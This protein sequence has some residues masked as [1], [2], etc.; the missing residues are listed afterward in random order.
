MT[1]SIINRRFDRGLFIFF[2]IS[3]TGCVIVDSR[4]Y[5]FGTIWFAGALLGFFIRDLSFGIIFL[6]SDLMRKHKFL[7]INCALVLPS[8]LIVRLLPQEF[9]SYFVMI[10]A[11]SIAISTTETCTSESQRSL[12]QKIVVRGSEFSFSLYLTHFPLLGL[13]S[14]YLTPISRWELNA[15]SLS[16]VVISVVLVVGFADIFA[17]ITEDRLGYLRSRLVTFYKKN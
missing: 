16:V 9:F 2:P 4:W 5:L 7:I 8:I 12:G 3:I 17:R 15:R 11:L 14:T 13:I 6:K 1:S 10:I